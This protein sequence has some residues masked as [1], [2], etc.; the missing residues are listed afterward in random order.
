MSLSINSIPVEMLDRILSFVS[1]EELCR[2]SRVSKFYNNFI[3]NDEMLWKSLIKREFKEI[4][5][6]KY[7]DVKMKEIFRRELMKTKFTSSAEDLSRACFYDST[8]EYQYF[9]VNNLL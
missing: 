1:A 8:N 4:D 9:V 7:S 2:F 5:L 3:Y 6:N